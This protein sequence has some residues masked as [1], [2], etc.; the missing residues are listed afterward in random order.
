[1]AEPEQTPFSSDC[2]DGSCYNDHQALV[3]D[4]PP[5]Q[6]QLGAVCRGQSKKGL[7]ASSTPPGPGIPEPSRAN[8]H[9]PPAAVSCG[10][11]RCTSQEAPG[12]PLGRALNL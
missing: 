5:A 10:R 6:R 12:V 2:Q 4:K 7:S 8:L 9:S 11:G 1:M 3:A